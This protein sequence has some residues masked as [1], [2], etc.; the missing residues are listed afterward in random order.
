DIDVETE[1]LDGDKLIDLLLEPTRIYVRQVQSVMEKVDVKAMSHIT[2]GGFIENIPRA[3]PKTLG[4]EVTTEN[5]RLP[6]IIGWLMKLG[7]I[8]I[9]EAYNVFN[10]GIGFIL[11]VDS[12]DADTAIGHLHSIGEEAVLIGEVTGNKGITIH[13]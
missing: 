7:E 13:D 5:I 8:D 4:A 6:K 9:E 11:V 12:E 10:M 1:T 3:I 2:G